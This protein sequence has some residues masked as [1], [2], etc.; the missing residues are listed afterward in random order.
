M[1]PLLLI[2]MVI[3]T[4]KTPAQVIT[5]S[6]EDQSRYLLHTV[7]WTT[8]EK[9]GFRDGNAIIQIEKT[10]TKL[11]TAYTVRF[12]GTKHALLIHKIDGTDREIATNKLEGGERVFGP[13]TSKPIEM[14]GK[15]LLFYFKYLDKDSM[16]LFVSEVDKNTL[17]LTNTRY[18]YSYQ[19]NNVGIFKLAKALGKEITLQL[20]DDHSK[21]LVVY[22]G[23]DEEIFSCVL[24]SNL[25][26]IRQKKSRLAGTEDLI[27]SEAF[28]D[29]NGNSIVAFSKEVFSSETFNNSIARKIWLQKT[30]NAEKL[31]DAETWANQLELH[32]VHFKAAK[33]GEKLYMFGDYAGTVANAGIWVSEIQ[34]EKNTVSRPKLFAYAEDFKKR[35]YDIGFG[36]RKKGNYGILDADLELTEFENGDLA[37]CGS[38]LLRNDGTWND[39]DGKRKGYIS[40]FAGP[41]MIAFLKAKAEPVFTLIP[42]YQNYCGGSKSLFVP[43]RDKL[44]IIYNDYAKYINNELTDKVD[45]IRVNMV[46]E[47]SL[48]GAVVNKSGVIESRKML[49]EG[50]ARMN[51]FDIS[52]CQALSGKKWLIPSA[53]ADKKTDAMK[54][55]VVTME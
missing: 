13:V 18:L 6:V 23:N 1:K 55:A 34:T 37:V 43:Y 25:Q 51:F 7:K 19:Q 39:V 40:F 4:I 35:I 44:V 29:N 22:P 10:G 46:R 45:P 9:Q 47:L 24:D 28:L 8:R 17:Q 3:L 53:A 38:P 16:K 41:V 33:G 31:I 32:N 20:S 42:R 36:E 11:Q 14:G 21:L 49:V 12:D 15:I 50:I 26:L 52:S 27:V 5:S 48:A 2:V 30:N 54:V